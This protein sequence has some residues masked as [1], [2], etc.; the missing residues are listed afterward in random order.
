MKAIIYK[1]VNEKKKKIE[2]PV[3]QIINLYTFK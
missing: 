1:L 2:N 3:E